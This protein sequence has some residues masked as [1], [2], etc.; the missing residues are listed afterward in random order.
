MNENKIS[1]PCPVVKR[2]FYPGVTF[3]PSATLC[4]AL[5]AGIWILDLLFGFFD[6]FFYHPDEFLKFAC[7]DEEVIILVY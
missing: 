5:Q 1:N 6:L 7:L 4:V 3:D 2:S